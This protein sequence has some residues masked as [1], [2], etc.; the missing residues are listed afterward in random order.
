MCM[1]H[2][3]TPYEAPVEVADVVVVVVVVLVLTIFVLNF[4]VAAKNGKE[5]RS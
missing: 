1:V 5:G 3:H 4:A 2:T